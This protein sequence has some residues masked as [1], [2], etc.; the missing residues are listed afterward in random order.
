[1]ADAK[2]QCPE[3]GRE[4]E[5]SGNKFCT[6]CGAS[7]VGGGAERESKRLAS[8]P[9]I[10]STDSDS[11]D[12][13]SERLSLDEWEIVSI[14]P[15]PGPAEEGNTPASAETKPSLS[16][17]DA[18]VKPIGTAGA[19]AASAPPTPAS[20]SAASPPRTRSSHD[21]GADPKPT[22]AR[23]SRE[24]LSPDNSV[25]PTPG[26]HR[27]SPTSARGKDN[28]MANVNPPVQEK[29]TVVEEGTYLKG[30]LE[31]ACPVVVHGRVQGDVQAP[32]LTVSATGVVEGTAKVGAIRCEGEL[33]GE[34]DAERVELFGSVK[35]NTIIRATTIEM[36]LTG[37][38]GKKQIIFG[39]AEVTDFE[40]PATDSASKS[41][42]LPDS[43]ASE[44]R[45]E[46]TP[47]QTDG[48]SN[49]SA[50]VRPSQAPPP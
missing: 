43:E 2:A 7:F 4:I 28:Q 50:S 41:S 11:E 44:T 5:G 25:T 16:E 35:D 23:T 24:G 46:A 47:A 39:E 42:A 13:S 6:S 15:P 29:R 22:P 40:Q 12:T 34:F 31:S 18:R 26:K 9:A 1:M 10:V 48:P 19:P 45:V 17:T 38:R 36:K 3:C 8:D 14:A 27:A 30:N 32:S 49:G 21:S 20:V 33:A 37:K